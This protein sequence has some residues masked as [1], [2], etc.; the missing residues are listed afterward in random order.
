MD[1]TRKRAR[2]RRPYTKPGLRRRRKLR[3][4]SE[5]VNIFVTG[6]DVD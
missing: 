5:G 3:D 4:V 1:R 6:K 2:A